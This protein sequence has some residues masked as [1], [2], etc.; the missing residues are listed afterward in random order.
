MF[1]LREAREVLL[2]F[3][4]KPAVLKSDSTGKLIALTQS[5]TLAIAGKIGKDFIIIKYLFSLSNGNINAFAVKHPAQP[6][7]YYTYNIYLSVNIG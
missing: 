2:Q 7:N 5:Y 3:K 1:V 6:E 4:L